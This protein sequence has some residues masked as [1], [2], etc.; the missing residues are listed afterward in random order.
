[1]AKSSNALEM[2]FTANIRDIERE[3]KRLQSINS[4]AAAK[5]AADNARAAKQTQN[6]W[7]NTNFAK[8]FEKQTAQI[9]GQ[10]KSMAALIA[11]AFA[12]REALQAAETWTRFS[13]S[14]K[15]AG[16]QG[17][18]LTAVQEGLF[19]AATRNGVALEPLA[20]LYGRL[21]Q[22]QSDL[23]ATQAQMMQFATGVTNALRVQ[24]G[25]TE[26]ARGALIQLAQAMGGA[27]VR[28]EEW[29]SI[30]EGARPILQ[31]VAHGHKDVEGSVNKLRKVM[32]AGKLTSQDFFNA[33]LAGSDKLAAQASKAPLTVAQSMTSLSSALAKF[34]G[35]TNESYGV[36]ERMGQAIALLAD[37]LDVVR[38]ALLVVGGVYAA[39]FIPAIGRAG[40]AMTQLT[41]AT[42]RSTAAGAGQMVDMAGRAMGM[43]GVTAAAQSAAA[44]S[45]RL[46]A[47]LAFFGGPIGIAV[48]GLT[49][50]VGYF[51]ASSAK[52]ALDQEEFRRRV[53]ASSASLEEYRNRQKAAQVETGNLSSAHMN[54]LKHTASLTGQVHLL[55]DAYG[56]AAVEAKRLAIQEAATSAMKMR[57]EYREAKAAYNSRVADSTSGATTTV[58]G[59]WGIGPGPSVKI[60]DTRESREAEARDRLKGS[61]EQKNLAATAQ[62][63]LDA[64]G[65]YSEVRQQDALDFAPPKPGA[66]SENGKGGRPRR[67]HDEGDR[68][69][70][71]ASNQYLSALRASALTAEDRYNAQLEALAIDHA[72]QTERLQQQ[73]DQKKLSAADAAVAQTYLDLAQAQEVLNIEREKSIEVAREANEIA[74]M[75]ADLDND[76]LYI[77][78]DDL[79]DRASYVRDTRKRHSLERLALKKRQ[80]ADDAA[81]KLQQDQLEL[82]RRRAGMTEEVI[83]SLREAAEANRSSFATG[84]QG[85]LERRHSEED[86][87]VK[88][89]IEDHAGGFG[90]LNSQLGDIATDG[91]DK[92]T[93][94]I[95]D[96]IMG[97]GSLQEAFSN[98]AKSIIADLIQMAVRFAI[99]E[100]IGM[101]LG[102]PG[103]GKASLGLGS[104]GGAGAGGGGK[105]IANGK[106]YATGTNFAQGGLAMVGEKGP[107]LL[108]MP[109]GAQVVPNNL[110]ASAMQSSVS[111]RGSQGTTIVNHTTV[112]A[113]DA[114]LTGQVKSWIREGQIES[115]SAATQVMGRQQDSRGRNRLIR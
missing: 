106:G 114:V 64:L 108:F 92:L 14:L 55:A 32:L 20:Q 91:L 4:K 66:T 73:V 39:T 67:D 69:I 6:A 18:K 70:E 79:D 15:V 110:L 80:S 112:N 25:T 3:L 99:F 115:I 50:A 40:L 43:Y 49:A 54:A 61:E 8:S 93:S 46:N 53:S 5:L 76:R 17:A 71:D 62:N 65:L 44:A 100:A 26:S 95:T 31:A 51:A 113:N 10:L 85:A 41:A 60:G 87:S 42:L 38:D 57:G 1:M 103:L 89:R 48:I 28:A 16:L 27:V 88:K 102:T 109:S 101:A 9:S 77:E 90:T 82:D 78:A 19:A 56:R 72:D 47:A 94:G 36:T 24:G 33:F 7:A 34:I 96:A 74:Q 37:N 111:P 107:E 2:R 11:G 58:A 86:P 98:M 105:N 29:N 63:Y 81:F 59:L 23:G 104:G 83:K 12:G 68:A 13:N 75:Q 21:A 22:S 45:A 52:A 30:N 35:E 97:A 84:E